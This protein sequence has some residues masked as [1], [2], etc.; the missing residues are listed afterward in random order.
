MKKQ[1][2]FQI[3]KSS[4]QALNDELEPLSMIYNIHIITLK[5]LFN[6][7]ILEYFNEELEA[8]YDTVTL[9]NNHQI[10]LYEID[11]KYFK[12]INLSLKIYKT[13]WSLFS[14]KIERESILNT[15]KEF[16]NT[17]TDKDFIP[18]SIY[19]ISRKYIYLK[20]KDNTNYLFNRIKYKY[21]IKSKEEREFFL[22]HS[23]IWLYT[24]GLIID[25][26]KKKKDEIVNSKSLVEIKC[27]PFSNRLAVKL[28]NDITSKIRAKTNGKIDINIISVSEKN[29][30]IVLKTD[31][32]IPIDFINYIDN[33][34][35]TNSLFGVVFAKKKSE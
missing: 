6:K 33:Y 5:N 1:S 35:Y 22:N 32:F 16:F 4:I 9:L 28:V 18:T 24:P 31:M 21:T 7:S 12:T 25:Q 11:R 20:H 30:K 26:T 23:T 13:I 14:K 3:T 34:I 10:C 19:K 15:T 17:F 29:R 2:K 8:K 27:N